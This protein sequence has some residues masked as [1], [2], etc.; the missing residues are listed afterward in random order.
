[1]KPNETQPIFNRCVLD[2]DVEKEI[3][4]LV[5]LLEESIFRRMHR[6]GGVVGISGGIDSSV[7]L[8]LC[9]R[10]LGPEH[11]LGVLLPEKESSPDSAQLAYQLADQLKVPTVLEEIS[12]I[13][14]GAGC[15]Q[16][17]DEA[18]RRLVPEYGPGWK[19][20]IV[21]GGNLLEQ[22]TLNYFHLVVI[23]PTQEEIVRR[24]PLKE[25]AQIVAASNFKQRARMSMLYYHAELRNFA[26][27]GTPNK[28]EQM[29]GFFVKYGD[30]GTDVNPIA[31]LYKTQV[32]Q[33][34]RAL[35]I[36]EE[37]QKRTPTTDTYSAG[38]T[39]E[40]FFFRVPFD[41][42]DVIWEGAE[43]GVPAK[44]I[45]AAVGLKPDQVE[46]IIQ[47]LARKQRNTA[48]LR[49]TPGEFKLT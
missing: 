31:H 41:V 28:N 24:L 21:L 48:Y 36:P 29:L 27:I 6:Q 4:R 18:I 17:R 38:S 22:A 13:L 44:E 34:A 14:D 33:L 23:S 1:M 16:R 45:A 12:P 32:Y 15:Y 5:V 20:K 37:I 49:S 43:C 8:A 2:L 26:V 46:R 35:G 19:V 39:Q 11:T 47:D 25:F 3:D 7:V 30:G 10:A 40:E 42:L 9:A